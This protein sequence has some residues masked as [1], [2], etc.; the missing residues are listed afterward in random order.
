MPKLDPTK[1]EDWQIAEAAEQDM[2]TV[3]EL[4]EKAGV[5]KMELYPYGHYV[6][7]LDYMSILERLKDKPDGKYV[8]VPIVRRDALV[9]LGGLGE[10]SD[11]AITAL[12]A[13]LQDPYFEARAAAA[14]AAAALARAGAEPAALEPLRPELSARLADRAFE[15]R[16]AAARALGEIG[17]EGDTVVAALQRL[18]FD[19]VWKV[20]L[21]VFDALA[22]LVDRDVLSAERA[23]EE[24]GRVLITSTGY[25]TEYPLKN[26]YNRLHHAVEQKDGEGE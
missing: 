10:A 11:E 13:G 15:P 20:R 19:K 9:G 22:R 14:S 25:V 16:A 24:M 17:A 23:R 2:M 26:A 4:A 8:E 6:G 21:A 12:A 1:M 18:Y 7:K 5:R 3:D